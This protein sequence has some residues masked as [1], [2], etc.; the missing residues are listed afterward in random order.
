MADGKGVSAGRS[1]TVGAATERAWLAGE[2][3]ASPAQRVSYRSETI[4]RN[5]LAARQIA[6]YGTGYGGAGSAR[7]AGGG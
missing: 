2:D 5:M 7:Q 3:D 4:R 1:A 6:R